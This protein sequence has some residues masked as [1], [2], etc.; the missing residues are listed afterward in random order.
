MRKKPDPDAAGH[1]ARADA[2][3]LAELVPGILAG[4]QQMDKTGL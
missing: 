2:A 4:H 3:L 1:R